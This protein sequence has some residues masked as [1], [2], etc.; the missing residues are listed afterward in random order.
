MLA[1]PLHYG[2]PKRNFS[3][4]STAGLKRDGAFDRTYSFMA[5]YTML[6][7]LVA[8]HRNIDIRAV[9]INYHATLGPKQFGYI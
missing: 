2:C 6:L 3:S 4:A 5:L 7:E 1:T 8:S 9:Q